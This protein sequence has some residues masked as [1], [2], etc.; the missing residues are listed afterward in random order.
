[1]GKNEFHHFWPLPGNTAFWKN[2]LVTPW[3]NPS[4]VHGQGLS[5]NACKICITA[6]FMHLLVKLYKNK[7]IRC[8]FEAT[9]DAAFEVKGKIYSICSMPEL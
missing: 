2:P 8:S 1:V 9:A 4:D 3:K 6:I 5:F 7:I